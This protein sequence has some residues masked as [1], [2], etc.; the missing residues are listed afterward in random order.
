[1]VRLPP[2]GAFTVLRSMRKTVAAAEPFV[3]V[4]D[5]GDRDAG[6]RESPWP[7]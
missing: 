3:L 4:H 6:R 1:M 5:Q 2:R 7:A